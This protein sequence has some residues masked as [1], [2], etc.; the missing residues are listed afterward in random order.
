M[1]SNYGYDSSHYPKFRRWLKENRSASLVVF[2]Y[3][4]SIAL[5]NGK[6][7]VSAQGGTWYRSRLMLRQLQ[8]DFELKTVRDDSL[9][10]IADKK[11]RIG[12]HL[13]TNPQQKILHTQQ[14]E[15]NGF[16]HSVLFGTKQENTGY[17]Y[18]GER[19]YTGL[20]E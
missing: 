19:A 15:Y 14:V 5:Y 1:D 13:K 18:F 9:V 8:N 12:F 16:I 10:V 2:A 6:P 7:V 11:K 3:N 17:R 20:I 4:D